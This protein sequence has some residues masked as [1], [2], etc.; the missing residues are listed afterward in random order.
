MLLYTIVTLY[1]CYLYPQQSML[2]EEAQDDL[3]VPPK[4]PS[5]KTQQKEELNHLLDECSVLFEAVSSTESKLVN[6]WVFQ[7][8][9][10]WF[11][12]NTQNCTT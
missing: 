5:G 12:K 3:T 8:F 7:P 9:C 6:L 2:G 11:V 10:E 4:A 1:Y